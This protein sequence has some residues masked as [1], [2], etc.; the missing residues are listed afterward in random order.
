MSFQLFSELQSR[1]IQGLRLLGT[2]QLFKGL[3]VALV[4]TWSHRLDSFPLGG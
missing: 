4:S 1:H 3:G 2:V